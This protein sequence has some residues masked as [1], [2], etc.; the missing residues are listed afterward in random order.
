MTGSYQRPHC[1][2]LLMLVKP[3][4]PFGSGQVLDFSITGSSL[5][6]RVGGLFAFRLF[7]HSTFLQLTLRKYYCVTSSSL[8][9]ILKRVHSTALFQRHVAKHHRR[10]NERCDVSNQPRN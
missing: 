6:S 2:L 5:D 10:M 7:L 8:L 4:S 3:K 9:R 1:S